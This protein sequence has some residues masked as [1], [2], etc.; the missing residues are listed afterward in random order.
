[1]SEWHQLL[2]L[3]HVDNRAPSR[4]TPRYYLR[5][6]RP[7]LLVGHAPAV[8]ATPTRI[9]IVIDRQLGARVKGTEMIS[10]LYV[11]RARSAC[12]HAPRARGSAPARHRTSFTARSGLIEQDT[13]SVLAWARE[14]WACVVVNLHV[15]HSPA[16]LHK[17][18]HDFRRLIDCAADLGRQ[19]L[20]DLSALGHAIA[21]R[22]LSP[23]HPRV[24][25]AQAPARSEHAV[26]ERLVR[27]PGAVTAG[28]RSHAQRAVAS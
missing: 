28:G 21:A 1:M 6:G 22:A 23:A 7:G 13:E 18:Q 10:E 15:D 24:L 19:L 26:Y 11:R 17:A 25:R 14:P 2:C 27:A 5:D 9:T 16:G 3:A 12:L 4:N 20:P 8:R